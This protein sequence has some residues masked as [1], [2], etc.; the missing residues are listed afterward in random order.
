M[1]ATIGQQLKQTRLARNLNIDQV[2]EATRIRAG[3]IEAMEADDYDALPS[4]VQARGFLRIYAEYLGLSLPEL[5]T[6]QKESLESPAETVIPEPITQPDHPEIE[7]SEV[8][9]SI[10]A[11]E[12]HQIGIT[13]P[14]NGPFPDEMDPDDIPGPGEENRARLLPSRLVF[15]SIGEQLRQRR[16]LL[17]LTYEEVERH[18]RIR[19]NALK[20][21]DAGEFTTLA[22]SVQA[23]GMLAGY[24]QFLNLDEDAI[25][26]S[27]AEGL[28]TQLREKAGEEQKEPPKRGFFRGRI[29][30]SIRP[31]LS[32][33][34]FVGLG[35]VIMLVVFAVWGTNRVISLSIAPAGEPTAPSISDIL[36]VTPTPGIE[37]SIAT[38]LIASVTPLGETVASP[39]VNLPPLQPG[40]VQ[41]M[42]VAIQN[43]WVRVTVDGEVKFEGRVTAGTAYTYSANEQIEVLTG[44]GA[45]LRIGYNQTDLGVMGAFGEV[46]NLIYTKTGILL[47][48]ATSTP[49][50]SS[51]PRE[52]ATPTPQPSTTPTLIP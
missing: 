13:P 33:D 3:Y 1:D 5:V 24:A 38:S 22:S 6:K 41:L 23:R 43:T 49:T 45:A 8:D 46:V 35:L 34:L 26:L 2:V 51:T 44:N 37:T 29:P 4:Q 11:A 10:E 50:P 28:Q 30:P 27:F 47:P 32:V 16:E 25:L 12:V 40:D 36:L 19:I 7:P 31:I 18:T 21:L 52:T 48:T 42:I 17:S 39:A 20:A 14:Q 9:V 15:A